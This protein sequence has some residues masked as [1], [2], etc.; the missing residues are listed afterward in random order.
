MLYYKKKRGGNYLI[1]TFIETIFLL[2]VYKKN[3]KTDLSDNERRLL[4][5]LVEILKEE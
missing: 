1:R 3:E 4:K 2:D 5:R